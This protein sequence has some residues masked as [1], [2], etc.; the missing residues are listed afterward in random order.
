MNHLREILKMDLPQRLLSDIPNLKQAAETFLEQIENNPGLSCYPAIDKLTYQIDEGKVNIDYPI[1]HP[2]YF[3]SFVQK[4]LSQNEAILQRTIMV[5]VFHPYWLDSMFDYNTEGQWNQPKDVRIPSTKD[6]EVTQPKPDLMITFKR[7]SLTENISAPIPTE[8]ESCISPDDND[9][10]RCF[11]FVFMEV[12]KA[13]SDLKEAYL[14]NLHSAAQALYNIYLWMV[15][16]SD[17]N[18]EAFFQK[19]RVFSL[20]FNAQDLS[21]RVHR[22]SR[23]A[24]GG[25]S[26]E[27]DE[28]YPLQ[29]YTKNG[30]CRLMISILH[31]YA[32]AELHPLLKSIFQAVTDQEALQ[33]NSKRKAGAARDANGK[34]QRRSRGQTEHTGQTP[35]IS[36][37]STFDQ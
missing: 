27:F 7:K 26:F 14:A 36:Q 29:R 16:A 4:C 3:K 6:D 30:T 11:P 23:K 37:M 9:L 20:V 10:K 15:R 34:K 22:V 33:V 18:T 17:P 24:D 31:D 5:S 21:V 19:V 32:Q 2:E 25:L 35:F 1:I 12:K 8:L 13:G 28:F